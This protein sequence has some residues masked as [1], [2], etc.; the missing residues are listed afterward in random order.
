MRCYDPPVSGQFSSRTTLM[1][2]DLHIPYT[3]QLKQPFMGIAANLLF[4]EA[5]ETFTKWNIFLLKCFLLLY[6][7][8]TR[9]C[10]SCMQRSLWRKMKAEFVLF[11]LMFTVEIFPNLKCST[12]PQLKEQLSIHSDLE[13]VNT[14]VVRVKLI[15]LQHK[16]KY[17]SKIVYLLY[18]SSNGYSTYKKCSLFHADNGGYELPNYTGG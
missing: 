4:V 1:L 8:L 17:K 9:F 14:F 12:S 11:S 5:T 15:A 3:L 6:Y 13:I 2:W 10:V 7:I 18:G 16:V